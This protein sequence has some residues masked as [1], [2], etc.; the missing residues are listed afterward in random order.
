MFSVGC[1]LFSCS[2]KTLQ[3]QPLEGELDLPI[4][5]STGSNLLPA[6]SPLNPENS[7][8]GGLAATAAAAAAAVTASVASARPRSSSAAG[9]ARRSGQGYVSSSISPMNSRGS[10]AHVSTSFNSGT[11]ASSGEHGSGEYRIGLPA[12]RHMKPLARSSNGSNVSD[13]AA[14][15]TS[16][17]AQFNACFTRQATFN[18]QQGGEED[19]IP[20][21]GTLESSSSTRGSS[22]TS[23][24][25]PSQQVETAGVAPPSV[26]FGG[27]AAGVA[28]STAATSGHKGSSKAVTFS[29]EAHRAPAAATPGAKQHPQHAPQRQDSADSQQDVE[30]KGDQRQ[31]QKKRRGLF[32]RFRNRGKQESSKSAAES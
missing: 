22:G 26:A 14:S 20:I 2:L 8:T 18:R 3:L 32:G 16:L 29:S 21:V 27:S 28:G 13:S 4:T 31:D 7:S 17:S 24:R 19:V 30:V 11:L 23:I 15:N 6:D 5:N 1:C 12:Q 9:L 25:G 10:Y